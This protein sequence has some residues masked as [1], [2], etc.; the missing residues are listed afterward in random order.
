MLATP[1]Y[2]MLMYVYSRNMSSLINARVHICVY[3][4]IIAER[5]RW[6][7]FFK[8]FLKWI[9]RVERKNYLHLTFL[10]SMKRILREII[11]IIRMKMGEIFLIFESL[12]YNSLIL[13]SLTSMLIQIK[14]NITRG[15]FFFYRLSISLRECELRGNASSFGRREKLNAVFASMSFLF[16]IYGA[17]FYHYCYW[18]GISQLNH[19]ATTRATDEVGRNGGGTSV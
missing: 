17:T 11:E 2:N 6:R 13:I 1:L 12:F 4:I 14:R 15:N 10:Y 18:V 8:Q 3:V 5:K 9:F 7:N 16:V 19:V